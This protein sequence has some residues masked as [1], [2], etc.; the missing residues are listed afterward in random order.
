MAQPATTRPNGVLES[1][2]VGD[3][4]PVVPGK[5]KR[6]IGDAAESDY[7]P[8]SQKSVIASA[9]PDAK[10]QKELIKSYL[11]VLTRYAAPFFSRPA[12][13]LRL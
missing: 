7:G 11:D 12:S 5:R 6:D 4:Q 13:I 9:S 2:S 10:N 8:Q 1:P 3:A